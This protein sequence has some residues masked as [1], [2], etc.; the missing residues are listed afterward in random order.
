VVALEQN[1]PAAAG[2]HHFVAELVHA[3]GIIAGAEQQ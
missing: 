1:L 3:G 2:A